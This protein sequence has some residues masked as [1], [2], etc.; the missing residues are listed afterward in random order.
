MF[1]SLIRPRIGHVFSTNKE[2]GFY[3]GPSYIMLFEL[4][5]ISCSIYFKLKNSFINIGKLTFSKNFPNFVLILRAFGWTIDFFTILT[6]Y[7]R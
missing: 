7:R 4:F 1:A 3:I 5:I 2:V 6:T